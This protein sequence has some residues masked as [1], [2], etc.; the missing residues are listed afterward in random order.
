MTPNRL[1]RSCTGR[2]GIAATEAAIALPVVVLLIFGML[3]ICHLIH[4]KQRLTT[5]CY[6][7]TQTMAQ[8]GSS[9]SE[10]VDQVVLLLQSQGIDSPQVTIDPPAT[11]GTVAAHQNYTLH[12]A[13]PVTSNLPL[14]RLIPMSGEIEVTSSV[15]Q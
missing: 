15:F 8:S 6:I 14:P 11:L 12:V 2:R 9:E 4:L 1:L 5:A 13:A 10:V 3:Q 7:G